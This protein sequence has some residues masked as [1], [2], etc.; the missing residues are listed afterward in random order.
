MKGSLLRKLEVEDEDVADLEADGREAESIRYQEFQEV[1]TQLVT[2]VE[3]M[4]ISLENVENLRKVIVLV[5]RKAKM[6]D[7]S[8]VMKKVI[9]K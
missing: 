7:A 6:D 1:V 5:A 4:V 9:R 2:I 3:R 8:F